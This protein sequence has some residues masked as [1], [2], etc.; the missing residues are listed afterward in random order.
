MYLPRQSKNKKLPKPSQK[1][2]NNSRKSKPS[3]KVNNN[4][5]KSK[6]SQMVN[7]KPNID[8]SNE[9]K[10]KKLTAKRINKF[11]RK[12]IDT[13]IDTIIEK[14]PTFAYNF[15]NHHCNKSGVC[16][17]LGLTMN[18]FNNYIDFTAKIN[19]LF[20]NFV[21][22]NLVESESIKEL[23]KGANGIVYEIGYSC[24]LS[25]NKYS[26]H[27]VLKI[28]MNYNYDAADNLAYEY[29]VGKQINK[30]MKVFPCFLETYGI[31]RT[32]EHYEYDNWIPNKYF[33]N[34]LIPMSENDSNFISDSCKYYNQL[35]VL[36][37]HID[38]ATTLNQFYFFNST[39]FTEL[40]NLLTT[41]LYQ[42]YMPL[43]YLSNEFT[44][45]DLSSNN[46]LLYVPKEDHYIEYHYHLNNGT[47]TIFK[48][49]YLIKIIDY[50]R[51]FFKNSKYIFDQIRSETECKKE[52]YFT[53]FSNSTKGYNYK[54]SQVNASA[55]LKLLHI[56]ANHLDLKVEYLYNDYGENVTPEV[57]T[58]SYIEN[59]TIYNVTDAFE[60]LNI[61][62]IDKDFQNLN[63]KIHSNMKKYG[64][65]HIY[66]R[67]N[68]VFKPAI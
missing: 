2:N 32:L 1:V 42:I 41:F 22:F 10:I 13:I 45:H 15:L 20:N 9:E 12:N 65:L 54:S 5:R 18:K 30:F 47:T 6:P 66:G 4:S 28:V 34:N 56:F 44:H 27:C 61:R 49:S 7:N 43:A 58:D 39:E 35:C 68:S 64:E 40:K 59:D 19:K 21:D 3:Q 29:L 25:G 8:L 57:K 38:N 36:I 11:F 24:E 46:V 53:L 62:I 16:I 60:A 50:G 31:F 67:E 48:S 17:A 55:D 14:R 37:Q 52:D 33:L 23:S 63:D 26:A 51:C